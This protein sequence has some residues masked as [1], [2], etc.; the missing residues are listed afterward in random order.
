MGP[1]EIR[2]DLS[3][4]RWWILIVVNVM[5]LCLHSYGWAIWTSLVF[6][7]LVNFSMSNIF[8]VTVPAAQWPWASVVLDLLLRTAMIAAG[9]T[10]NAA[11]WWAYELNFFEGNVYV[12]IGVA[13]LLYLLFRLIDPPD[14][15]SVYVYVYPSTSTALTARLAAVWPRPEDFD[16]D[17]PQWVP[18]PIVRTCYSQDKQLQERRE[19]RDGADKTITARGEE[20]KVKPLYLA[21]KT[22]ALPKPVA[23]YVHALDADE[24]QSSLLHGMHDMLYWLTLVVFTLVMSD[25]I[26]YAEIA[27]YVTFVA[28]C[29]SVFMVV[30]IAVL[31]GREWPPLV[32]FA[33]FWAFGV[34]GIGGI[35]MHA[36]RKHSAAEYFIAR[37]PGV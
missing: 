22:K 35:I 6:D 8:E 21:P 7:L 18:L 28:Y 12:Y 11:T 14:P 4:Q 32:A 17:Q 33:V 15:S 13:I 1:D 3:R 31:T 10:L 5:Y 37:P 24:P 23:K 34:V 19:R 9:A 29:F 20:L 27:T 25:V 36:L 26:I 2:I 30:L 16:A